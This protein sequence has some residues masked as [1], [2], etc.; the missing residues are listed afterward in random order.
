MTFM[1][2][3]RTM[4]SGL[5]R[6]LVALSLLLGL[7]LTGAAPRLTASS[8]VFAVV[9]DTRTEP[10]A[11]G[12]KDQE[13]AIKTTLAK[14]YHGRIDLVFDHHTERL[15]Q[16]R[17]TK[18]NGKLLTLYYKDG[19]PH[20]ITETKK[21]Q[22]RFIMHATGR[23]W[24]YSRII[25]AMNR[26]GPKQNLFLVHGGDIV[27]FGH[28]VANF[29]DNPYWRLFYDELLVHLP[30]HPD[31]GWSGRILAAVGN[32]ETWMDDHIEGMLTTMPWLADL[33]LSAERRIYHVQYGNSLFVFL[34]SGGYSGG[35]TSWT[36]E[37]PPFE[38]QMAFLRA[39]LTEAKEKNLRHVF[40]VY[41]KPSYVQVGHDPLPTDQSPHVHMKPFS[42]DL[43]MVVFNS[44]THTT[45]HYLI[46]NIR[47]LVIGAGGAPQK[48]DRT[49]KP[50]KEKELY[51]QGRPRVEEYNYL[52][53]QVN[54]MRLK[55]V[56]HRYR[57][58]DA[59][60]LFGKVEMFTSP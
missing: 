20:I 32:H 34:D 39:K 50:S 57:P 33:G 37:H 22:T 30:D 15:T 7:L 46:D 18:K 55:G 40:V 24:V 10:Y 6:P 52:E 45:E 44:H 23:R 47:Y 21:G 36:G 31:L 19:W 17:V 43:N 12:S 51:W 25:A 4:R 48:F 8:F 3:R 59:G 42:K 1:R 9:G 27:L 60:Q 5:Y 58:T 53:V 49:R 13:A 16:A 29:P 28:P 35:E 26:S 41:H 38:K 54:G 14:R 2:I 11:P 56:L